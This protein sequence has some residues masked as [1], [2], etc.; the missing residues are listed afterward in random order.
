MIAL[1]GDNGFN[2]ESGE[3][4][5]RLQKE[6]QIRADGKINTQ[7]LEAVEAQMHARRSS[8][9][10]GPIYRDNNYYISVS[11][12]SL[13]PTGST[14]EKR[15]KL[16]EIVLA[17][18]GRV[19]P[20]GETTVIG[21]RGL[22]SSP[23]KEETVSLLKAGKTQYRDTFFVLPADESAAPSQFPGA[24]YSGQTTGGKGLG[25]FD[26]DRDGANDI[27]VLKPGDYDCAGRSRNFKGRPVYTVRT[28]GR[29]NDWVPVWR[30]TSHDGL[31]D[32]P[33]KLI[34]DRV[35]TGQQVSADIGAYA[36]AILFHPGAV[37]HPRSV[38]CQTMTPTVF[39]DF[40]HALGESSRARVS[41]R[42]NPPGVLS[43]IS[44]ATKDFNYVLIDARKLLIEQGF[45]ADAAEVE[46]EEQ[47]GEPL[48]QDPQD[49]P[50]E[51]SEAP[52]ESA[53]EAPSQEAPADE[54]A[55]LATCDDHPSLFCRPGKSSCAHGYHSGECRG[56][57]WCCKPEPQLA[58]CDNHPDLVCRPGRSSCSNGIHF[59]ECRGDTWCCK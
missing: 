28:P 1:P 4:L 57:T 22:R 37:S 15:A 18:D 52:A 40:M 51:E 46:A 14:A 29:S 24:T 9:R 50:E 2:R 36:T 25:N 39:E 56:D 27:G 47:A 21:M 43:G 44:V 49:S 48:G 20:N 45:A 13:W 10:R 41:S 42:S 54:N 38:G 33:E 35:M 32:L 55:G 26:I 23:R 58:A 31:Y 5:C 12:E 17:A 7:T 30:D 3:F 11:A 59:G 16:K 8:W 19:N 53:E 6:S 34:S